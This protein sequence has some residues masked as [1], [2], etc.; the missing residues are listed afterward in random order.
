[1]LEGAFAHG[2]VEA[3]V[4]HGAETWVTVISNRKTLVHSAVYLADDIVFTKNGNNLYQPWTLMRM[5]DPLNVYSMSGPLNFAFY[6][7]NGS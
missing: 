6:R 2:P 1:M 3:G 7:Q 4:W 5:A